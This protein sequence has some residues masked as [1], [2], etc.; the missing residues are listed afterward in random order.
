[1]LGKL[2]DLGMILL[3][4][5]EHLTQDK[6]KTWCHP[7]AS[8]SRIDYVAVPA[9]WEHMVA[10]ASVPSNI[11]LLLKNADDFITAVQIVGQICSKS[12]RRAKLRLPIGRQECADPDRN[13]TFQNHIA[14]AD[15]PDWKAGMHAPTHN[16]SPQ[17]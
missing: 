12:N 8:H 4:T 3:S 11:D 16:V 9:D 14:S 6:Q 7:N 17:N 1:M 15:V 5:M 2:Q 13:N 10:K